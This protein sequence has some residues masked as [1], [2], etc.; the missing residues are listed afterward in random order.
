MTKGRQP[1]SRERRGRGE[2]RM[3]EH[4]ESSEWGQVRVRGTQDG[5]I[6]TIPAD[7][8]FPDLLGQVRSSV[9]GTGDFFRH[10]EIVVD[11]GSRVPNLE[12]ILALQALLSER[13]V[14]VRTVT[15]GV[16]AYQELLRGWGYHPLR[17]VPEQRAEPDEPAEPIADVERPAYYVRRTLRSGAMVQSED[18]VIV[19]GDVNAGAEVISGGDVI[20]W[21]TLRGTVHAGIHG[22]HNAIISALRFM[23][24]Q[25]RIGSIFARSP[26]RRE[27]TAGTPMVAR[28]SG[29]ELVVE[30]WRTGRR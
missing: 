26:D 30:P 8:P 9:E 12:E 10:G 14:R 24:T 27:S 5:L 16:R 25:L 21:G 6:M 11:Y 4:H 18:D 13:G 15:A 22:D 29:N 1:E 7:L 17:P 23:P 2:A 3:A 19:F 20:V 28:L